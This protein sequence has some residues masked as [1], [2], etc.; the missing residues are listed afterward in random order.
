[1]PVIQRNVSTDIPAGDL[2][3]LASLAAKARRGR[4]VTV[5]LMPPRFAHARDAAGY[6]IVDVPAVQGAV[7][8]VLQHPEASRANSQASAGGCG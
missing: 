3:A 7:R 5:G 4:M 6:P 8:Q 1:M 2:P